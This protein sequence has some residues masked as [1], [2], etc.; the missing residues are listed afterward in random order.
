MY[1]MPH[2]ICP[3]ITS[4]PFEVTEMGW[5]EFEAKMTMHFKDPNENPV[6][7]LHQLRL[8]H[9]PATGTTQPKKASKKRTRIAA[10][11]FLAQ[12]NVCRLRPRWSGGWVKC[13]VLDAL[14][15]RMSV[16]REAFVR[17][18]DCRS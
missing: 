8:Y 6:D 14:P 4:P 3:E 5:G 1:D 2:L 15:F 7:V 18:G 9:D 17:G 11:F 12:Q 16:Y 10:V 13:C